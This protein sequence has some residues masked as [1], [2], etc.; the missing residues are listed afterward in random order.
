VK[1]RSKRCKNRRRKA[2]G[3]MKAKLEKRVAEERANHKVCVEK[4][5]QAWQLIKERQSDALFAA[6]IFLTDAHPL[7]FGWTNRG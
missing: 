7:I 1:P 2:R 3:D 5:R 4:L 6:V